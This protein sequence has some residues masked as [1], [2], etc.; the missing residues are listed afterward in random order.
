MRWITLSSIPV[1][2]LFFICLLLF[3]QPV[4]FFKLIFLFISCKRSFIFSFP[5]SSY[6]LA[7]TSYPTLLSH[8]FLRTPVHIVR[9]KTK[10][11]VRRA[12]ETDLRTM[13]HA[14]RHTLCHSSISFSGGF[15][16]SQSHLSSFLFP[17]FPF[18]KGRPAVSG[19]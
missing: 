18:Q 2:V 17:F 12:R 13:L 11:N 14:L 8:F 4:S 5:P 3:S 19:T 16:S 10:D 7:H 15:L 1:S 6:S 9:N